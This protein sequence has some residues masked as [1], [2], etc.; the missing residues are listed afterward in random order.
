MKTLSILTAVAL[1]LGCDAPPPAEAP[2]S[3]QPAAEPIAVEEATEEV[4]AVAEVEDEEPVQAE[5]ESPDEEESAE[6]Y[7]IGGDVT[8]PKKISGPSLEEL[9]DLLHHRRFRWGACILSS[10][11]T[12]EGKVEQVELLK[13]ER[14]S[15]EVEDVL[16]RTLEGYRFEPATKDGQPVAVR[17]NLTIFHCPHWPSESSPP[18][19][20]VRGRL[21]GFGDHAGRGARDMKRPDASE[22]DAY[23]GLYV[24]QVPSGDIFSTLREGVRTTVALLS[25]LPPEWATYR[26]AEDKWSLAD[27]L[28]HVLDAE[29]VFAYRGMCIA[30]GETADLP[31]MDQ[32]LYAAGSNA[33]SRPLASLLDEF[34]AVRRASVALFAGMDPAVATRQ[35]RASG[36]P[37]TVRTFPWI[38]AGHEIHHRKVI[39]AR[40]LEPLLAGAGEA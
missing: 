12:R 11:V 39:E 14:V 13:P 7:T 6:P 1:A 9:N 35:G 34:A 38:L 16:V 33:G 15:S 37:F 23:Y 3:P 10:V 30:R 31:S 36:F 26:Y 24:G 19:R 8:A 5:D 17:Y 18:R 27:V 20:T 21:F 2:A 4:E 28:G 22:Y 29:R 32:D 25:E 40:Y